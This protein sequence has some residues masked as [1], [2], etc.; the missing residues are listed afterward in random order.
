MRYPLNK[1]TINFKSIILLRIHLIVLKIMDSFHSKLN[2]LILNIIDIISYQFDWVFPSTIREFFVWKSCFQFVGILVTS[3]MVCGKRKTRP[4]E[5]EE[6]AYR[7]TRRFNETKKI[8]LL[9]TGE[10]GKT[11]IIKQMKI[12]HINGFTYQ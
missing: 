7:Y 1:F 8:L 6:E 4:S 5:E 10:S 11:T 3:T 9:G 2:G 12:L